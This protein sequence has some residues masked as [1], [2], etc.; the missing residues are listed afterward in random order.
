MYN[1]LN[2]QNLQNLR[3]MWKKRNFTNNVNIGF[4]DEICENM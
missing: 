3:K 2:H 4:Y 1:T